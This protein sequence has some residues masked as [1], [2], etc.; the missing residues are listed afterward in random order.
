MSKTRNRPAFT[1]VELL[2][3]IAIIGI[4]IAMLLPAVQV[5][6]EAARRVQCANKIKQQ[7]LAMLNYESAHMKF[8]PGFSFPN[9]AMWSAYI[10]PFMDQAN[11]YNTLDFNSDFGD[12]TGN[13]S[14]ILAKSAQ[15]AVLRCPS[16]NVPDLEVDNFSGIERA[17]CC[18]LACSS[19]LRNRE[20]GELPWAGMNAFDGHPASDGM[21]YVNSKTGF[22]AITDGSSST[23]LVGESLP[24]QF[25]FGTDEGGNVQ[26]ADHW[27]VGSAEIFPQ[28]SYSSFRSSEN[29]ECLGST[30]CP[31]NSILMGDATT[32]DEK[33]LAFGS[34]H[35]GGANIGFADGHVQLMI[36]TIEA[37]IWSGLGTRSGG[38]V[39]SEY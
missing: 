34:R 20:A 1:L 25:L 35:P 26:K 15:L 13:N 14:N 28:E 36:D 32:I 2:V 11:L 31:I 18:Y 10:L 16:A 7:S 12:D 33:E 24:D 19:G 21:F 9:Q 22:S 6:R 38:E 8:P 17:P 5:I 23:V 27:Y 39:T 37:T 4:L 3:V 30:A 29:S